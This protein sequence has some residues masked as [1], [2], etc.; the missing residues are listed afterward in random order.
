MGRPKPKVILE[1]YNKKTHRTHQIVEAA[2]TYVVLYDG[3]PFNS[4]N[5]MTWLDNPMPKYQRTSFAH[6]GSA[7]NMAVKL[8]TKYK[9]DKFGVFRVASYEAIQGDAEDE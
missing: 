8:N 1:T 2:D 9:T 3:K 7:L 5:L 6:Y 4:K